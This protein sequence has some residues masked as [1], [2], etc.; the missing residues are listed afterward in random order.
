MD[1]VVRCR[2][3]S[4]RF[5]FAYLFAPT[6]SLVF[7]PRWSLNERQVSL[8]SRSRLRL[9]WSQCAAR[10]C[11]PEHHL[12]GSPWSWCCYSVLLTE[13]R[14][15]KKNS[16]SLAGSAPPS[17]CS[18]LLAA[19]LAGL[20][21]EK[22]AASLLQCCPVCPF[23]LLL[24]S[25]GFR[26]LPLPFHPFSPDPSFP[27]IICRLIEA[28]R[29]APTTVPTNPIW[30]FFLFP[31]FLSP[32]PKPIPSTGRLTQGLLAGLVLVRSGLSHY[33]AL[34]QT[35]AAT[36]LV[37]SP[38][39]HCLISHSSLPISAFRHCILVFLALLHG[40]FSRAC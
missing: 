32:L 36:R 15:A 20:P 12:P 39:C 22:V 6:I 26:F 34:H 28:R 17:P 40:R 29:P 14:P 23:A 35:H 2:F 1:R 38:P 18:P 24:P 3:S 33:T 5:T 25:R 21:A 8:A 4:L 10:P 7:P 9:V 31:T 11:P 19:S 27:S 30:A 16:P 37:P 13:T